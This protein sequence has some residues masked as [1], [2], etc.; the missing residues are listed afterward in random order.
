[1]AEENDTQQPDSEAVDPASAGSE[2][3]V[4]IGPVE[5]RGVKRKH[6]IKEF[7]DLRIAIDDLKN[8][9]LAT[10]PIKELRRFLEWL[11]RKP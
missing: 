4:K 11:N 9:L 1:M 5:I 10:C 3:I 2:R 8:A 6:P 7:E